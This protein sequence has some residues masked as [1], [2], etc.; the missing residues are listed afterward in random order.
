MLEEVRQVLATGLA[1]PTGQAQDIWD[2]DTGPWWRFFNDFDGLERTKIALLEVVWRLPCRLFIQSADVHEL[3]PFVR[4]SDEAWEIDMAKPA[5]GFYQATP[6]SNYGNWQLYA[7]PRPFTGRSID[8]FRA[9]PTATREFLA[10]HDIVLIL[11]AFYDDVA[12][13]IALREGVT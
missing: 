8:L 6:V 3:Q 4:Q 1:R 2:I 13:R 12:W 9:K 11:D 5:T 7:A 10:S